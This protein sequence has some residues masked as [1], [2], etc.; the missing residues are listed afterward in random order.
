[1]G[2]LRHCVK[3]RVHKERHQPAERQRFGLLE[4]KKDYVKRAKDFH[5]KK[6]FIA[7]LEEKA[8]LKNTDEFYFKMVR[9]KVDKVGD[10]RM[11]DIKTDHLTA[12]EKQLL[13]EK[14]SRYMM[15]R[16]Q[17]ESKRA[18][19]MKDSL[20]LLD[21]EKPNTHVIFDDSPEDFD[22]CKYF[23]TP[24]EFMG[25]QSNRPTK[26][27]LRKVKLA[28][29]GTDDSAMKAYTELRHTRERAERM[30]KVLDVLEM[31]RQNK[32]KD[33][34]KRVVN[35]AGLTQYKFTPKRKR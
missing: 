28:P 10:G 11:K 20:H 4:K 30:D 25:L 14:D 21:V 35:T 7:K 18:A 12:E 27:Q 22:V 34:K 8:R 16:K 29:A 15:M 32:L 33:F 19:K 17:I 31:R 26:Q 13:E 23:D 1:M 6:D 9:T 24:E 3:R 2:T 5:K